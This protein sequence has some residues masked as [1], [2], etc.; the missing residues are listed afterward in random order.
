VNGIGE[1]LT[2]GPELV[3][4]QGLA[5]RFLNSLVAAWVSVNVT[6]VGRSQRSPFREIDQPVVEVDRQSM[7]TGT[8][9]KSFRRRPAQAGVQR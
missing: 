7:L 1:A 9:R 5:P 8:F 3:L 6:T 2:P 4:L